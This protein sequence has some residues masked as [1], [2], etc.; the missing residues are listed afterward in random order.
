MIP[1]LA[2]ALSAGVVLALAWWPVCV[3]GQL[4]HSYG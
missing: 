2:F 4:P 3:D 1:W